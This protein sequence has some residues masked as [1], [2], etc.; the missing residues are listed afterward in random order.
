M[1]ILPNKLREFLEKRQMSQREFAK[2]VGIDNSTVSKMLTEERQL[3]YEVAKKIV[4]SIGAIEA[5]KMIDWEGMKIE[6]PAI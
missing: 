1:K 6:Q 4:Y 2:K 5:S 3:G